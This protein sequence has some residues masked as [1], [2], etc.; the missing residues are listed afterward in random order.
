MLRQRDLE[1]TS[2]DNRW[3]EEITKKSLSFIHLI[4]L[5]LEELADLEISDL[6]Q[7]ICNHK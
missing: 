1:L 3:A 7:W 6:S 4:I 5:D 2:A